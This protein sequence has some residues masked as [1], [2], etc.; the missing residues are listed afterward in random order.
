MLWFH[1]STSCSHVDCTQEENESSACLFALKIT[2]VS[3]SCEKNWLAKIG[4]MS[5]YSIITQYLREGS[6]V[7]RTYGDMRDSA[8]V[9]CNFISL[10]SPINALTIR[11]TLHMRSVLS[12]EVTLISTAVFAKPA[13]LHRSESNTENP[14][15]GGEI[16]F[17][18]VQ[19][20]TCWNHSVIYG[21]LHQ[22]SISIKWY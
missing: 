10:T 9:H 15:L 18:S 12:E 7:S 3:S 5:F 22:K 20:Q 8:C 2:Y 21:S 6:S 14:T 1:P 17:K 4:V 13:C 16:G 19:K 11:W